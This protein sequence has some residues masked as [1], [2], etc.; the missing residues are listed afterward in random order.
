MILAC[1]ILGT[2]DEP[3]FA[4]RRAERLSVRW[5]EASRSRL[6]R[7]TEAGTD[8]A[9]DVPRGS[10]LAEGAVLH[11]DDQRLI[12]VDRPP[13]PTL[14]VRV[15]PNLPPETLVRHVALVAHAFGNQHVP[16][17]VE[18]G[19]IR[20][21]ITTSEALARETVSNLDLPGAS[22]TADLVPLGRKSPLT[23]GERHA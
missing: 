17:E 12:V 22:T 18:G 16:L 6:R 11:D 21:P 13:E 8:V 1:E 20:V 10:Y 9:I 4:N 2:V 14:R 7:E 3:R 23:R 5:S 15:D 19:E